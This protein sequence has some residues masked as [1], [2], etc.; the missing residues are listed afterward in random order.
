L[1]TR[2]T[3]EHPD[4]LRSKKLIAELEAKVASTPTAS[5]APDAKP[6]AAPL[7]M[8][9]A[10][11]RER[12]SQMKAEIDSLDR[13]TQFK[14]SEERRLRDLI[15]EY[16]R[17]IEAVPGLESEWAVLNRDYETQQASY[18][19]LLSKSEASKVALDLE[20]RQIGENF[21]VLDPA[22]VPVK[23]VSPRRLLISGFG[24]VA[25]V[26]LVIAIIVLLEFKDAS[27]RTEDEIGH[28]LAVPVLAVVPYVE[29]RAER[30]HRRWRLIAASIAAIAVTGGAGYVF[31]V[32]R[33]WTF[34]I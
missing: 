13:L 8:E 15:A 1:E 21:R 18:K 2:L 30:S 23:P 10:Q 16:Q 17:R 3:S 26:A 20:Q 28:V 24:F 25:G 19:Q 4:I 11:R 12:L 9:Q 14:E 29:T 33:L 32:M 31:W 5:G 27:F 7:T 34:V 6:D 22:R